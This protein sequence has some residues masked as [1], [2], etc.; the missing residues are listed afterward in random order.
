SQGFAMIG[1]PKSGKTTLLAA[2][3]R[4]CEM[5]SEDGI[6]LEF[7]PQPELAKKIELA[8]SSVLNKESKYDATQKIDNY[9]FR[10]CVT[11]ENPEGLFSLPL[12]VDIEGKLIDSGGGIL[13]PV[14]QME[15]KMKGKSSDEEDSTMRI[16]REQSEEQKNEVFNNLREA[17]SIILCV[18]ASNPNIPLLY[19]H[20][21]SLLSNSRDERAIYNRPIRLKEKINYWIRR[22]TVPKYSPR[23]RPALKAKRFLL[24]LTHIDQL[25]ESAPNPERMARLINPVV[26]AREMLGVGLLEKISKS[27]HPEK[28]KFAVG[29]C[30]PWG[31]NGEEKGGKPFADE[32]GQ[33]LAAFHERGEELLLKWKPFGVR[34]AIYFIATGKC[35]G[36]V[37]EVTEQHLKPQAKLPVKMKV[38]VKNI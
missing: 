26:Q 6:S 22:K 15:E 8:I 9:G 19:K 2:I 28:A 32:N 34:D 33:V 18:D 25:C 16:I 37:A 4:A 29:V 7:Y 12:E 27:L 10:I 14:A 1:P 31:F 20:M 30:S 24:L 17:S 35:R 13:F 21:T 23:R 3:E 11:E 5:Y 38:P 36:S